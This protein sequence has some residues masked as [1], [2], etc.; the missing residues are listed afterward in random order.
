M[1]TKRKYPLTLSRVM[2][3]VEDST[4]GMSSAGFCLDCGADADGVE[5]DAGEYKCEEC[6]QMRVYGAEA[7]LMMVG[8]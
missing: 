7:V 1:A 5:P 3:A 4:F 6:G 2:A 8:G